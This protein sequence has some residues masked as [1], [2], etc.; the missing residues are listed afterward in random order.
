MGLYGAQDVTSASN[1]VEH[2]CSTAR[3][4]RSRFRNAL[5]LSEGGGRS[6]F[7]PRLIIHVNRSLYLD[8]I[9]RALGIRLLRIDKLKH[10]IELKSELIFFFLRN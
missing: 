10:A 1:D 6:G 9:S 8:P 2:S 7:S 5:N 4:H 3:E